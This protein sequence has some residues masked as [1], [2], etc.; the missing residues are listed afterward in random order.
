M[1]VNLLLTYTAFR[2]SLNE[3]VTP[4]HIVTLAV[5]ADY[6]KYTRKL[7]VKNDGKI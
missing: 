7:P 6:Y 1:N 2:L 3:I 4:L 5:T